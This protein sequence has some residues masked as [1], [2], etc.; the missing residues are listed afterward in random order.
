MIVIPNSK[1]IVCPQKMNEDATVMANIC[2]SSCDGGT[3]VCNNCKCKC[4]SAAKA[5]DAYAS[6]EE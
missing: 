4:I 6:D 1:S 2:R 5:I 3:C